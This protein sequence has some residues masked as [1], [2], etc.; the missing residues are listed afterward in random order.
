MFATTPATTEAINSKR[1]K[2]IHL[3][4]RKAR[5]CRLLY[6]TIAWQVCQFLS[7]LKE[8]TELASPAGGPAPEDLSGVTSSI[9]RSTCN[10]RGTSPTQT[11]RTSLNGHDASSART[12]ARGRTTP[13]RADTAQ[14]VC[15]AKCDLSCMNS[16]PSGS[17]YP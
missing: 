12:R 1:F 15:S 4:S 13:S 9:S 14:D 17:S 5:E 10:I 6:Y 11:H 3:L 2:A 8:K 7:K 16:F